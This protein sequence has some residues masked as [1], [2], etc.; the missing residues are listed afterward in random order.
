MSRA[1]VFLW[2]MFHYLRGPDQS[3]P[4]DDDYSRQHPFKAPLMRNLTKE[5]FQQENVDPPEEIEWGKRMSAQRSAILKEL[6][7]EME[8]EKRRKKNP[9]VIM[10]PVQP[11]PNYTRQSS[12]NDL[13][14]SDQILL[15][16]ST[17][18]GG[19][20]TIPQTTC[21]YA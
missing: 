6:V 8:L 12:W 10:P 14:L 7:D 2:I 3:N 9:P 15:L 18:I 21:I 1:K 5:E 4:F 13:S 19:S 20:S 17:R 16:Y 11:S